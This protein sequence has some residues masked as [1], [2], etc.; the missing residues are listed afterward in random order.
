[1]DKTQISDKGKDKKQRLSIRRVFFKN[2]PIVIFDEATSSLNN[3]SEKGVQNALK[4]LAN[5]R[6]LLLRFICQ[7]DMRKGF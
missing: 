7:Q 6:T 2:P 4:K 5:T 3:E 1:M